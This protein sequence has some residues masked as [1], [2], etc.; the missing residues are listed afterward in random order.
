MVTTL[1]RVWR[2][3]QSLTTA[4]VEGG[5]ADD[6]N[7]PIRTG[8]SSS[9]F[10]TYPSRVP[11]SYALRERPYT[12]TYEYLRQERSFNVLLLDGGLIQ[13]SYEFADD[14]IRRHRLAFLPSPSLLPFQREPELYMEDERYLHVL[15]ERI[16]TVPLRFDF[17]IRPGVPVS[18]DHPASHLTL[19]QYEGCRI[20]VTAPVSPA[21]FLDFV[22]RNFYNAVACQITNCRGVL[23]LYLDTCITADEC[24]VIHIC[25]PS[26]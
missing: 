24:G 1:A 8:S 5:F 19:G 22:F 16:V 9:A 11:Q 13:I 15:D 17:D 6:Q 21:I 7:F 12:E 23:P 3:I 25:V 14:S 20:P 10:I 4:L 2:E 26:G 18:L